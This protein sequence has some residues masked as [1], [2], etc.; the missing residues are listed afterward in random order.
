MARRR[1]QQ[2]KTFQQR[3]TERKLREQDKKQELDT[4]VEDMAA[5]FTCSVEVARD[6]A[7]QCNNRLDDLDYDLACGRTALDF[8][9]DAPSHAAPLVEALRELMAERERHAAALVELRKR[10][11]ALTSNDAVH[12]HLSLPAE[13]Y[14]NQIRL[15]LFPEPE[16][17][18]VQN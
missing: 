18:P 8:W 16:P 6:F 13:H 1:K 2:G 9:A 12:H 4:M 7:D 10:L 5:T 15:R 3:Q 11:L 17:R 14:Q